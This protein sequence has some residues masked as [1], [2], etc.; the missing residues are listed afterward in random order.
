[1]SPFFRKEK[2]EESLQPGNRKMYALKFLDTLEL[3]NS[4]LPTYE[5]LKECAKAAILSSELRDSIRYFDLIKQLTTDTY[6][7]VMNPN[8]INGDSA[9]G[10]YGLA[11]L[12]DK[13]VDKT[14]QFPRGMN[15]EFGSMIT[16]SNSVVL[17]QFTL[18]SVV[19]IDSERRDILNNKVT[20]S[21]DTLDI[22]A[23]KYSGDDVVL[24]ILLSALEKPAEADL[25]ETAESG[26][27]DSSHND[28]FI[29]AKNLIL[30]IGKTLADYLTAEHKELLD[31]GA[32]QIIS[33]DQLKDIFEHSPNRATTSLR[34]HRHHLWDRYTL[35]QKNNT[36][37]RSFDID[38]FGTSIS[39]HPTND[40]YRRALQDNQFER[41]QVP[42]GVFYDIHLHNAYTDDEIDL[43]SKNG[44]A[45]SEM[46]SIVGR[47]IHM[48]PTPNDILNSIHIAHQLEDY[49]GLE[50][51]KIGGAILSL[52]EEE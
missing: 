15:V 11:Y 32:D 52:T 12:V 30:P 8:A 21:H 26:Y 46:L 19:G 7:D 47:D 20:R 29:D 14:N 10:V 18:P 17:D 23:L 16:G 5:K 43:A 33:N 4:D 41:K 34:S 6:P 22:L 44:T 24:G 48:Y 13:L 51:L 45:L 39:W 37:E 40:Y 2:T 31:I 49:V 1:M 28:L 38:V 36:A 25:V 42:N 9:R 50:T 27:Q 3:M 35:L